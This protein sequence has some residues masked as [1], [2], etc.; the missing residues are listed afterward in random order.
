M[1]SR[2][3]LETAWSLKKEPDRVPIEL[4]ITPVAGELPEAK[5]VNEFIETGADNF[6]EYSDI[7]F[8][9]FGLEAAYKEEVIEDI[10]G[11]YYRLKRIYETPAGQFHAITKHYHDELNPEDYHWEK[12]YIHDLDDMVRLAGAP[13]EKIILNKKG[14]DGFVAQIGDRGLPLIFLQ[15]P[16]GKL[17]RN[18]NMEEVY[19]WFLSEHKLVHSFLERTNEQLAGAV[20]DMGAS[21][22]GPYYKVVAHEM[23]LP[24]WMG[25]D[26]FDEYIFPYDK[27]IND[28]IHNFGGKLRIHCHGN[29]IDQLERLSEMG[30]DA[31]EPL[32]APPLGD[33]DMAVAKQL[34]GDRMLLSGNIP[35]ENF[36]TMTKK[37]VRK[38]VKDVIRVAAPGG[39]FTLRTSGYLA[40]TGSCKSKEQLKKVLIN[41]QAYI[42]AALEYG[43]YPIIG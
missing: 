17:V 5:S 39:G 22:I 25:K 32:E 35:S 19:G 20:M 31:I 6:H 2:E 34:V 28:T 18:A 1:N 10:P 13:R 23:L 16:L 27:Y 40:G 8:G 42:D 7:D 3:R 11:N 15:H 26:L 41:I 14:Y 12:R 29:C 4:L 24:P 36:I 30:V 21:G 38:C 43:N 9:F 33:V 37:D